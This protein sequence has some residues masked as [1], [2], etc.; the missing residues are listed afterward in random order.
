MRR[1]VSP[2]SRRRKI[3]RKTDVVISHHV[4]GHGQLD[5]GA[6]QRPRNSIAGS[7]TPVSRYGSD[8][9]PH[10]PGADGALHEISSVLRWALADL[11]VALLEMERQLVLSSEETQSAGGCQR[12]LAARN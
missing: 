2:A 8:T 3:N 1:P 10:V 6:R 9:V 12:R 4:R 11:A 7:S 5:C